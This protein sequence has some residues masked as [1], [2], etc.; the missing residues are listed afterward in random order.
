MTLVAADARAAFIKLF[1]LSWNRALSASSSSSSGRI[2]RLL[3]V[4]SCYYLCP[5]RPDGIVLRI[6]SS[7]AAANGGSAIQDNCDSVTLSADMAVELAQ[8]CAFDVC[9]RT[10]F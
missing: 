10:V 9:A 8:R 4:F 3:D 1:A 6:S 7:G 2:M 5:W